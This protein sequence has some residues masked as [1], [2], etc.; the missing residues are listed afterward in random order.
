MQN[1]SYTFQ[2]QDADRFVLYVSPGPTG[3]LMQVCYSELPNGVATCSANINLYAAAAQ[4]QQPR[5]FEDLDSTKVYRVTVTNTSTTAKNV[6]TLDAIQVDAPLVPFEPSP[7]L[8][9]TE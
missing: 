4:W 8:V 2:V 1:N 9:S 5:Y 6:V 3:G 7:N